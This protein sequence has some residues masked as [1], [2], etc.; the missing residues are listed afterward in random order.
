[1]LNPKRLSKSG[2][3]GVL[4]T[5]LLHAIAITTATQVAC[6]GP[7]AEPAPTKHE[8]PASPSVTTSVQPMTE[9]LPTEAPVVVARLATSGISEPPRSP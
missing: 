9:A 1:M 4:R 6:A 3:R 5:Q 2:F 7:T 8:P